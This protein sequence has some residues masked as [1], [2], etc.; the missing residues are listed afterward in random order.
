[1]YSIAYVT[2]DK[3]TT[4]PESVRQVY[5]AFEGKEIPEPL[6]L[7]SASPT[8]LE[9]KF[10]NIHYYMS[11]ETLSYPL[12]AAI[13]YSVAR[14]RKYACCT[15]FNDALLQRCG[16]TT[17]DIDAMYNYAEGYNAETLDSG[18]EDRELKLV[19][20]VVMA[21][22]QPE[23]VATNDI[24]TLRIEGWSDRD[25]FDALAHGA[26]MASASIIDTAFRKR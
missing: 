8:L 19:R 18:L 6:Q 25:I 21:V 11:H 9:Q 23:T 12:L 20:F 3:A 4:A 16:M 13:R 10:A 26:N 24:E 14:N 7:L 5:A 17:A 1:M 22:K 2:P 15:D